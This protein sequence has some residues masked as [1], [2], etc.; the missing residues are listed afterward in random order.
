MIV[1]YFFYIV[2]R[3]SKKVKNEFDMLISFSDGETSAKNNKPNLYHL[4]NNLDS[5]RTHRTPDGTSLYGT[6][7]CRQHSLVQKKVQPQMQRNYSCDN[8]E[9]KGFKRPV[10]VT[11]VDNDTVMENHILI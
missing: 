7:N 11:A 10:V 9:K 1:N 6:K 3:T 5:D 2:N 4:D 8:Y